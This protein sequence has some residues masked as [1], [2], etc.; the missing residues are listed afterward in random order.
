MSRY[1]YML[2]NSN[3]TPQHNTDSLEP[4]LYNHT[5]IE[6]IQT[7]LMTQLHVAVIRQYL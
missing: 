1:L 5:C 7:F 3:L 2:R 6:Q 4:M